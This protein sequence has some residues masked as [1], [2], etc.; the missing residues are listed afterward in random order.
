MEQAMDDQFPLAFIYCFYVRFTIQSAPWT[1][2][3]GHWYRATNRHTIL[4]QIDVREID[5]GA[6]RCV[7]TVSSIWT[8]TRSGGVA[9]SYGRVDA[10]K[11]ITG[12]NKCAFLWAMGAPLRV[13]CV[14][15]IKNNKVANKLPKEWNSNCFP[16]S[17]NIRTKI[18][19]LLITFLLLT[20]RRRVWKKKPREL[21]EIIEPVR[22]PPLLQVNGELDHS[23]PLVVKYS[24]TKRN[25]SIHNKNMFL[26]ENKERKKKD[27]PR[28][29]LSIHV[30]IVV[31][32]GL[33]FQ[34]LVSFSFFFFFKYRRASLVLC[35]SIV[36][37]VFASIVRIVS[38]GRCRGDRRNANSELFAVRSLS[39]STLE[40]L[41]LSVN[42]P[43]TA[44]TDTPRIC[45]PT[46]KL[47]IILP[48][49]DS[50]S[51]SVSLGPKR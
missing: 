43:R 48:H 42:Y 29:Q 22:F 19:G 9:K 28:K 8:G 36:Y 23:S 21:Q 35:F 12:D 24:Q 26:V 38:G 45:I 39:I 3:H 50:R 1:R 33:N 2:N 37:F 40:V 25:E 16:D 6:L 34:P 49:G 46:V 47:E 44:H 31:T 17:I 51:R 7:G 18:H 27:S 32:P 14:K 41:F 30:E 15:T 5:D 4:L 10:R 20:T 11:D 13:G